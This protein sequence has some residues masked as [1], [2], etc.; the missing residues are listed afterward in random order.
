MSKQASQ[1]RDQRGHDGMRTITVLGAQWRYRVGD[2]NVVFQSPT[3]ARTVVRSWIVT[4][5]H[6]SVFEKGQHK[7]TMDGMVLPSHVATYIEKH[8]LTSGAAR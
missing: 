1:H 7:R 5:V 3:G 2:E 8:L 6:P 4:G